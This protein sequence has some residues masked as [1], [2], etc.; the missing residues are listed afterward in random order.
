M[1]K[2]GNRG[3][4]HFVTLIETCVHQITCSSGHIWLLWVHQYI[5]WSTCRLFSEKSIASSCLSL[6]Q[7]CGHLKF[8][9]VLFCSTVSF[10]NY[11]CQSCTC[12]LFQFISFSFACTLIKFQI[13]L[14]LFTKA[15]QWISWLSI[16]L[17]CGRSWVWL[18]LDQHSGS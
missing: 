6:C 18:Q 10:N 1:L 12:T 13:A 17:P 15:H 2:L 14:V 7:Y 5:I 8:L 4:G 16:G 3:R 9:L 11:L